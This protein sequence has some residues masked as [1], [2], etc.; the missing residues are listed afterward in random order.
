M[1]TTPGKIAHQLR[2]KLIDSGY[3]QIAAEKPTLTSTPQPCQRRRLLMLLPPGHL[4]LT[5][6]ALTPR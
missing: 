1:A 3:T 6:L 4:Q 5:L 2:R